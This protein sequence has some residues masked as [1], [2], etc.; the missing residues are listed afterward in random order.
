MDTSGASFHTTPRYTA[1][2]AGD[3]YLYVEEEDRLLLAFGFPT[4]ANPTPQG[5]ALQVLLPDV[6]G[7]GLQS[8]H[9]WLN[10]TNA[11]DIPIILNQLGW[12]VV[13]MGVEG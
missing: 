5:F 12:H 3:W 1:R 11:A 13:W 6:S 10:T 2:I 7:P 4:I 9:D 8:I